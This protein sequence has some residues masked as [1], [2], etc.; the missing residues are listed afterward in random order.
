MK[1]STHSEVQQQKRD[2]QHIQD[3]SIILDHMSYTRLFI[4]FL[5]ISILTPLSAQQITS[6]KFSFGPAKEVPGYIKV[7][8][9]TKS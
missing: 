1:A 2:W 7:E 6:Y 3:T 8:P 4:L 5:L 9:S